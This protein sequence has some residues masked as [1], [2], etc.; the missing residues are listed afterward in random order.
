VKRWQLSSRVDRL[1]EELADPVKTETRVDL[2]SFSE[3][4]RLLLDRVQEIVDRYAPALPPQDVV[5]KNA[6]LWCKGLEIFG[7]RVIELFVEVVPDTLL[8]DELE[9]WYFKLY[10]CNFWLDWQESLRIVR[11][12]SK[13]QRDTVASEYRE[14]GVFDRVF[15]F[16]RSETRTGKASS[17]VDEVK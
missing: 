3:P 4:E 10:F 15:R 7:R 9:R 1:S 16:P 2:N 12:M 13:E 8:C 14:L 6:G 11:G 5:E 17:E